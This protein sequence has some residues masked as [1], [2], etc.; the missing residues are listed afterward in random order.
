MLTLISEWI[1]FKKAGKP[2]WAVLIPFYN[3]WVLYEIINGRGVSMFRLLIPFYNIYWGI[4]TDIKVAH[5][6]GKST[7]F[8]IGLLFFGPI[9]IWILGLGSAQYVGPQKM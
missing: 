5:A 4:L 3:I 8:G 6:Y 9:F 2:G 7:G 1:L